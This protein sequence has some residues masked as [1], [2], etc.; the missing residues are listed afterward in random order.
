[1]STVRVLYH[2]ARADFLERIRRYGFLVTLIATIYLA[3]TVIAGDFTLSLGDYRGVYNSA[4]VGLQ[5]AM[6][7]T[8]FVSL[9]GF[10]VVKNTVDRDLQTRVGQILAAT[11]L[12]KLDYVLGKALSNFAVLALIAAL[13]AVFAALGQIWAG[14]DLHLR[15]WPLLAPF[16]FI[17]LPTLAYVAALAVLFE[18]IP[19]LRGGFGNIVY[20]ILFMFVL[21]F[22][23]ETHHAF[24]DFTA[25]EW[26]DVRLVTW[27]YAHAPAYTGGLSLGGSGT[28]LTER[29][30][31]T[32]F[33][34]QL[35]MISMRVYWLAVALVLILLAAV[36]FDRFDPARRGS[37]ER[38]APAGRLRNWWRRRK[39][40]ARTAKSNGSANGYAA[41]RPF[42]HLTPLNPAAV[43][44]RAAP[45][46]AAELRLMLK[47]QRWWWYVVAA[48]LM[49]ASVVE[50]AEKARGMLPW[51]W[52][53]PV[54]LWSAM[55]TRETRQQTGGFIFSSAHPLRRQFSAA[56]LAGF[57]VALL[58]GAGAAL[59]MLIAR[60][61]TGMVGFAAAAAFIP[62]L[63]LA[64]GVW[65]GTSKLFEAAYVI[66]W[67]IGPIHHDRALDFMFTSANSFSPA[68]L[69]FYV[70]ATLAL[71]ALA[72]F[73]RH[74]QLQT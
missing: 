60:D 62:T 74:R 31:W 55:G 58:M 10:Y 51:L 43:K 20:F 9:A 42:V 67:Y 17:A 66:W 18:V 61:W 24:F 26:L 11:P 1:M 70:L 53:W 48:G 36:L 44:F 57:V 3:Y 72:L 50:P 19:W 49:I 32:G 40:G 15:L 52:I 14:E 46:L 35:G 12:S 39:A 68:T 73:G 4:W 29:F 13:L 5:M 23:L 65:S 27:L 64:M 37:S 54:L 41:P 22:G 2:L 63:A 6:T 34:W 33:D 45:V 38:S 71:F 8:V 16:V 21:T 56:W 30:V 69:R 47:R 25:I 59:R 28:P 7:V